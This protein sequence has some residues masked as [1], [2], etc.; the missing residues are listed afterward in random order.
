L[1]LGL[2]VGDVHSRDGQ[3][4]KHLDQRMRHAITLVF[5]TFD[6]LGGVRQTLLWFRHEQIAMPAI[7]RRATWSD[8]MAWLRLTH[9]HAD[10]RHRRAAAQDPRRP[11]RPREEWTAL[12]RDRHAA[13][14]FGSLRVDERI[15]REVLRVLRPAAIVALLA[16]S[17]AAGDEAV[18][19]RQV[20]ELDLREA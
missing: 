18:A 4:E 9:Q 17:T 1:I 7:D 13:L 14:S 10:D 11:H 2:P 16:A 6:R 3:L 20:L 8:R 5:E 15:E 12:I 19:R